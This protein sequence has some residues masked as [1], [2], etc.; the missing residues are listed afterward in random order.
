MHVFEGQTADE[1]WLMAASKFEHSEGVAVSSG[2]D[3]GSRELPGTAFTIHHPRQ[4]WVMSR[5]P[6][7]NP[8]FAIAEVVWIVSGRR[9]AACLNYWNPKLP[10]PAARG[11]QHQGTYGFRLRNHLG[12]DQ[13]ERAYQALQQDP[14]RRQVVLQISDSEEDFS[15]TD[16]DSSLPHRSCN[17]SS[18]AEIREGKL[19][20]SQTLRNNDL[21]LGVPHNFV[22]FTYLHEILAAWLGVEPGPYRHFAEHLH[23]DV[24]DE[25]RLR[26]SRPMMTGENTDSLRF[27]RA[28]S[29]E[30]FTELGRRMEQMTNLLLTQKKLQLLA[31][32]DNLPAALHHWLLLAAAD[33]AR[34]RRWIHLA[35]ELMAECSN[36]ALNQLWERWLARS[37]SVRQEET[38]SAD[39]FLCVHPWLPLQ[40]AP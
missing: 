18:Y 20:W 38:V 39:A 16:N 28:E 24:W 10:S 21:F 2:D 35:R 31:R 15:V 12:V 13:L 1:V 4:R 5:E 22:Q 7:M 11:K 17:I 37:W 8:A 27:T 26:N 36:P 29:A 3:D 14:D 23:L 25:G 30:Y 32:A 34:R 40:F 33:S 19:E 9:D 6:A